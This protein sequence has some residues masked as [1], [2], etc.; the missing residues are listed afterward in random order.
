MADRPSASEW[1]TGDPVTDL[2]QEA[3]FR[4]DEILANFTEQQI[5]AAGVHVMTDALRLKPSIEAVDED[6]RLID[7][8]RRLEQTTCSPEEACRIVGEAVLVA[9]VVQGSDPYQLHLLLA[10]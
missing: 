8:I 9:T 2:Q 6:S 3:R 10:K 4:K 1:L 5:A 7:A